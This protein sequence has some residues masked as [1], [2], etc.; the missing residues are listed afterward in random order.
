M[1]IAPYNRLYVH[2][3]IAQIDKL[4]EILERR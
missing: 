4:L 3:R 1:S 2:D